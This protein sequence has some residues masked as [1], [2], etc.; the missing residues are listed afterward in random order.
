MCHNDHLEF[1]RNFNKNIYPS[2]LQ[3]QEE[4]ISTSEATFLNF[5]IIIGNKEFK[6]QLYD[7][8]DTVTFFIVCMQNLDSNILSNVYYASICSEILRF[9]RATSDMNTFVTLP[10][11]LLK[12]MQK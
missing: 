3:L 1:V 11:L 5:S 4:N 7:K 2:E 9:D 12:R 10:N 8:R 6:T